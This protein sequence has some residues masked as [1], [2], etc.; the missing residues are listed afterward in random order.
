MAQPQAGRLNRRHS[1]FTTVLPHVR[2]GTQLRDGSAPAA[3]RCDR[4]DRGRRLGRC[5]GA[6]S[7]P[8][9]GALRAFGRRGR[10]PGPRPGARRRGRRPARALLAHRSPRGLAGCAGQLG[11]GPLRQRGLALQAARDGVARPPADAARAHPLAPGLGAGTRSDAGLDPGQPPHRRLRLGRQDLRRAGPGAGLH[12]R[13]GAVRPHAHRRP[14]HDPAHLGPGARQLSDQSGQLQ[15]RQSRAGSGPR[16]DC[17]GRLPADAAG[18]RSVA[19]AGGPAL[20]VRAAGQPR[21][22]G[23]PG[24]HPQLPLPG[25]ERDQPGPRA[26]GSGRP[27]PALARRRGCDEWPAG[28]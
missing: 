22:G 6:G 16:A 9:S 26:S 8:L 4:G 25:P 27:G 17:A 14:A 24:A 12:H 10:G 13:G 15:P 7:R 11:A 23:Q 5:P 18:R 21:R 20:Q 28:S 19:G 3:G 1:A 2:E